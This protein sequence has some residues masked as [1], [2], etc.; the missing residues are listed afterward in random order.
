M[1]RRRL[2]RQRR[3]HD[4]MQPTIRTDQQREVVRLRIAVGPG[5][6]EK[7]LGVLEKGVHSGAYRR[8]GGSLEGDAEAVLVEQLSRSVVE[9]NEVRAGRQF[10]GNL[11]F[12]R[13]GIERAAPH[14]SSG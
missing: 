3:F 8:G 13:G 4:E 9:A 7:F 10:P 14:G 2:Q 11:R 5:N 12:G 6:V 1:D